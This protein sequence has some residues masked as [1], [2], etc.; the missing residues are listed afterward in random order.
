MKCSA[1]L[2]DCA[3]TKAPGVTLLAAGR[4]PGIAVFLLLLFALALGGRCPCEP[5]LRLLQSF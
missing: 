3:V 2:A 4:C 5:M 1:Q